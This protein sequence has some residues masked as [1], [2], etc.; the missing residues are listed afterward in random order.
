MSYFFAALAFAV[1][2]YLIFVFV[3]LGFPVR[4]TLLARWDNRIDTVLETAARRHGFREL[5]ELA[6]PMRWTDRRVWTAGQLLDAVNALSACWHSLGVARGDRVAIYKAN[7]FDYFLFSVAAI[8]L[9]AI[10][11]PMNANVAPETAGLYLSRVGARL[12]IADCASWER[13]RSYLPACVHQTVLADGFPP[14]AADRVHALSELLRQS[15]HTA[16]SVA[17]GPEDPLYIVHTSGTT[18]IPKG[19]ILKSE[20][21]AQSLR[22]TLLFNL[23]SPRD[24]ACFALPMNHQV[25]QLYLHNTLLLGMRCIING[26]LDPHDL[27]RQLEQRRPT[28][29]FGFPITYTRLMI[30]GAAKRSLS[31]VRIWGTTADASHEVQQRTF[32]PK[33]SFFRRLGLPVSGSLF[34]D[35]L[36][37]SEVGIAALLRIATPWTRRFDRRVGR[38][39][40]LGPRIKVADSEGLPVA[41]GSPGLL[42]IKGKSMFGGYWNAHDV[43]Y[44]SSRD[45]WWFTGDVVREAADGEMIHLDREVDVIHAPDGPVYTLPLEEVLLKRDG[46]LDVSVF[47]VRPEPDAPE[48]PAAVVALCEGAAPVAADVLLRELNRQL[49]PAQQLAHLWILHWE[50]FPIGAT[51]KTLKRRLRERYNAQ[52]QA[53]ATTTASLA[54][55]AVSIAEL[56]PS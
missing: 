52:L 12:L 21:I 33:G 44:A 30:A 6:R 13:V 20:G 8:R 9:G 50:D 11:V 26:D 19:V 17:R 18:G 3:H 53:S 37:S 4:L 28:I 29:F 40:P 32:L 16:P 45:G 54:C 46:V 24:L 2:G 22:S 5:I 49:E 42:M 51:G 15:P 14:T 27:L 7:D 47:G 39:T 23:I 1:L 35:G 38:K 10:A 25:S 48:R 31:S 41:K 55:A 34:I 36:G 56:R 43:L